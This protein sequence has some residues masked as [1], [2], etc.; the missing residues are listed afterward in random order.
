[1][2]F[3]GENL[4]IVLAISGLLLAATATIVEKLA[5]EHN[6]S[7]RTVLV[8]VAIAGFGVT[9]FAS[10]RQDRQNAK[11]QQTVDGLNKQIGAL[12]DPDHGAVKDI[13]DRLSEI[14]R[15]VDSLL[16]KPALQTHGVAAA[17]AGGDQYFVQ[18]AAD[19]SKDRLD[20]YAMK[21][22]RTYNVSADFA[23]VITV[24]GS[25]MPY[26]LTFGQHLDKATAQKY[27]EVASSLGLPPGGQSAQVVAQPK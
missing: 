27:A 25:K 23:A 5:P 7:A 15:D 3:I 8:L 22:Q 9:A 4:D 12:V 24:H 13:N 26:R 6:R 21:I 18:V 1:M 16:P 19:T 20:P 2:H 10:F 14:A 11:Q 17:P